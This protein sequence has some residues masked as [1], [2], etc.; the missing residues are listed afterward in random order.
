M[1]QDSLN[2]KTVYS[3]LA[4]IVGH[5]NVSNSEADKI[6]YSKDFS[7]KAQT[8][9][10]HKNRM[11][12]PD[13]IVW[14]EEVEQ[15]SKI[16]RLANEK[17]IPIIPWGGG[18]GYWGGVIP[19]HD[20]IVVDIKKLDKIKKIDEQS[21]TVTVQS[22]ILAWDLETQLQKAGYTLGHYPACMY[23]ACIG[24]NLA[25]RSAGILSSKYG[26]I[27]D[28]VLDLEVVLPTG[29]IIHT[30][31][32]VQPRQATGPDL[33]QIFVGSEGTLGI[34][35]E[36]TLQIH[37][38]PEERRFRGILF[39]DLHTALETVRKIFRKGLIP[40]LAR[41][42]DEFETTIHADMLGIS[43]EEKGAALIVGFDGF[44][45]LVDL[46]EKTALEICSQ[47][48][49]RDLGPKPGAHYWDHQYDIY[50]PKLKRKVP[51]LDLDAL[52]FVI[53]TAA[54]HDRLESIYYAIKA[55]VTSY[56][57]AGFCAHFSHWYKTGGMMYSYSWV[58][59]APKDER[60]VKKYEQMLR[61]V[62]E[63]ILKF[64]GTISHHHGVGLYLGKF[65]QNQY[66]PAFGVTEKIKKGL[67]PNN[68]MNPGKLGFGED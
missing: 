31:P 58:E 49:G 11:F 57:N 29:E 40:C 67:D 19:I 5:K 32:G 15:I 33:N 62:L 17:G 25:T 60:T 18:S 48:G 36:A 39:K 8:Q 1:T 45:E 54:T 47:E 30:R 6:S 14:P 65:M 16:V 56:E 63:V 64:G 23:C 26:K 59:N 10:R 28:M 27:E 41:V 35:T 4:E 38:S 46:E 51:I 53:D 7:W 3:K 66:G 44:K 68:I 50:Y 34:I 22:G 61:E 55:V 52:Q 42:Y 9:F 2:K 37:P 24:G 43:E 20:G 21:C 13:F 12:P